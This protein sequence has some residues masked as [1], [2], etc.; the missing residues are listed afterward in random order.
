MLV[1]YLT[2]P[3]G[4]GRVDVGEQCDDGAFGAGAC[5]NAQC[6]W[7]DA[8]TS[9]DD[10]DACTRDACEI[11]V[12]CVHAAGPRTGCAVPASSQLLVKHESNDARDRLVWKWRDAAV[13]AG[14][15]GDPTRT[16]NYGLCLYAGGTAATAGIP[17]GPGWKRA[18]R[19]GLV[20]KSQLGAPDGIRKMSLRTGSGGTTGL[21]DGKG[22][23][24][25][26]L[27]GPLPLPL[28]VQLVNDENG[29]CVEAVYESAT[30]N[31]SRQL[32]A[33]AAD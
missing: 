22:T 15:L 28:V 2:Q 20:M 24:L 1:R 7:S 21:V 26:S 5:C 13:A 10:G 12:G 3:C 19:T 18:G 30:R 23:N 9:C 16:T 25:P 29:T 31:D 17:A 4:N 6:R 8:G 32:R 27:V 14:G 33:R 11:G